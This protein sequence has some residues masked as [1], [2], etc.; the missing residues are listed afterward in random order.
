MLSGTATAARTAAIDTVFAQL[1]R[2]PVDT[3]G[4]CDPDLLDNG[5]GSFTQ[6]TVA[7]PINVVAGQLI[8]V[9]V[10]ISFS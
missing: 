3:Q 6:T 1:S 5:F 10:V 4:V 8:Q 7:T 9:T 2:C